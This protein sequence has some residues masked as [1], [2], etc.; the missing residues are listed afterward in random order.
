MQLEIIPGA[1]GMVRWLEALIILPK[2]TGSIPAP[3]CQL[4]MTCSSSSKGSDALFS[5][6][7]P[8]MGLQACMC[9]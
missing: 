7:A 9:A 4:T 5:L 8:G 2:D 3:S 1:R 6:W